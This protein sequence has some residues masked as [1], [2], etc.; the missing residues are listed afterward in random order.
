VVF[1]G[2]AGNLL[3][4]LDALRARADLPPVLSTSAMGEGSSLRHAAMGGVLFAR[5][6]FNP[7]GD[8]AAAE[9]SSLYAAKFGHDAD[10]YAAHAFDAVKLLAEVMGKTG[11]GASGLR[12][13]L[14]SVRNFP[15]AAGSTTFDSNGDV[16]QPFQICAVDA[17]RAVPLKSVVEQVLPPLQRRVQSRRFGR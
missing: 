4:L 13:G 9:F 5:P 2:Y 10:I 7:E 6:A 8:T 12:R 17:G 1:S 14:L 3:P 16:I 11:P 15:G